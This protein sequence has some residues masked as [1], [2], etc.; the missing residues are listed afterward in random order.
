[1][2]SLNNTN[3]YTYVTNRSLVRAFERDEPN[4]EGYDERTLPST[5]PSLFEDLTAFIPPPHL[6]DVVQLYL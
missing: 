1:M 4:E 2:T 6:S 3:A 5:H